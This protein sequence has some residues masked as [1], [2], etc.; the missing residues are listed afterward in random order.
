[1]SGY[2]QGPAIRLGAGVIGLDA[3]EAANAAGYRVVGGNCPSVGIVGGYTQGGGHSS[4]SNLYGVAAD[5]VLEWEVVTATGEHLVATPEENSDLYWALSG[6]GGGTYA[7]VLSMTSR[8]HDDGL[9][10]GGYISFDDTAIGNDKFWE[11]VAQFNSRLPSISNHGGVTVAYSLTNHAFAIYNLLR[12]A[13]G[14]MRFE[15]F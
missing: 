4:M 10:G 8:L 13:K 3:Y 14:P 1:M 7:V 2:Y 15:T 11:A 12:T 9:V 6:G 5:N